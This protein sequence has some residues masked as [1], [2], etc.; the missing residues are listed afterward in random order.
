MVEG[1]SEY[2]PLSDKE[3]LDNVKPFKDTE[4]RHKAFRYTPL[5]PAC[6]EHSSLVFYSLCAGCDERTRISKKATG[7]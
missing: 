4:E 3:V 5:C 1:C 6:A 7:V 2:Q